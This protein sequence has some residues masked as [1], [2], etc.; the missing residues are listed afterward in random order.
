M[1]Q[2]ELNTLLWAVFV[3]VVGITCLAAWASSRDE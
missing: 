2:D 1:S 3:L